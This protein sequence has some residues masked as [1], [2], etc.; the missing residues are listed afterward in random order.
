[1]VRRCRRATIPCWHWLLGAGRILLYRSQP[2][3][4]FAAL[5]ALAAAAVFSGWIIKRGRSALGKP[6]PCLYWYLAQSPV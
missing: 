3:Y 4:Y 2:A 1:V 5:L 6:N